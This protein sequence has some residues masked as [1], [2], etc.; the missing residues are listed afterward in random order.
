MNKNLHRDVSVQL[1]RLLVHGR[2]F[3]SLLL[4]LAIMNPNLG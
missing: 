2:L 4:L 1:I 3:L